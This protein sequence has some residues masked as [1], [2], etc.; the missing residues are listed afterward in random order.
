MDEH[1]AFYIPKQHETERLLMRIWQPGDGRLLH[2]AV[3]DSFPELH[4]WMDWAKV[5][6]TLSETEN[7]V[8]EAAQKFVNRQ[9]FNFIILRKSDRLVVG[10]VGVHHIRWDVPRFELGYW[11]RTRATGQGY[12][13]EAVRKLTRYLFD[14]LGAERVEIRCD[15]RNVRSAAVARRAGF[16]LEAV[17]RREA[18]SND[19]SLRDTQIYAM[20]RENFAA[21]SESPPLP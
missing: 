11:G 18:R 20:L 5:M 2:E 16:L 12:I 6:P 7:V 8:R 3:E 15:A 14:E 21:L 19:E 1:S 17:L 13:T 10:T 4:T 9:E